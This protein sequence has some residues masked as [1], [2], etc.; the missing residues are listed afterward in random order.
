MMSDPHHRQRTRKW[1]TTKAGELRTNWRCLFGGHIHILSVC[2]GVFFFRLQYYVELKGQMD[3][4]NQVRGVGA[5][6]RFVWGFFFES[7]YS[8]TLI[9]PW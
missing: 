2:G 9:W 8:I 5:M 1:P 3:D 4:L 7:F 6:I